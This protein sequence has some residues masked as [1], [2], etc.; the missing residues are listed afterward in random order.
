[1]DKIFDNGVTV[2]GEFIK[3]KTVIICCGHSQHLLTERAGKS[4]PMQTWHYPEISGL[5]PTLMLLPVK[6]L[7]E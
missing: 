2:D 7:N 1:M 4:V 3:A 6:G 5:P